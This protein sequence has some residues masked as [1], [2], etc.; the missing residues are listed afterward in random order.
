MPS[1]VSSTP[2]SV[3]STPTLPPS[4]PFRIPS[5]GGKWVTSNHTK[6]LPELKYATECQSDSPVLVEAT[7][8]NVPALPLPRSSSNVSMV[9]EGK[10]HVM[11]VM[12]TVEEEPV[13][14]TDKATIVTR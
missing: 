13:A 10:C 14:F 1:I 5:V 7:G 2:T 9:V 6:P 11:V 8:L 3:P 12:Q 4:S